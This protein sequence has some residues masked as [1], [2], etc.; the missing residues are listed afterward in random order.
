MPPYADLMFVRGVRFFA[1]KVSDI[2]Y[3]F[4]FESSMETWNEHWTK[5]GLPILGKLKVLI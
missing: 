3:T 4:A 1:S 5:Y 2:V